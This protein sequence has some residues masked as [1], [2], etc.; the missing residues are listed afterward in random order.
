MPCYVDMYQYQGNEWVHGDE[1]NNKWNEH[2]FATIFNQGDQ[3][4]PMGQNGARV[5]MLIIV[6]FIELSLR[7][8]V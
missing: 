6:F 4:A 2:A 7:W 3:E 5:G 1:P 8:V